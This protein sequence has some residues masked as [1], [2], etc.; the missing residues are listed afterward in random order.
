MKVLRFPRWAEVLKSSE[1]PEQ[2]QGNFQVTIRWYLSWCQRNSMMCSVDSAREFIDWAQA[3][4][5][6]N[7]WMVER[8]KAP[9]PFVCPAFLR[10]SVSV[11]IRAHPWLK[12]RIMGSGSSVVKAVPS[13]ATSSLIS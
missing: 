5:S 7:D 10:R 9:L 4:K 6:A 13:V 1:L 11:C 3:E 2:T 12:L 8:W